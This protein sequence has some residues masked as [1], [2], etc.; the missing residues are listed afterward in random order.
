M[1]AQRTAELAQQ[2][3]ELVSMTMAYKTARAQLAATEDTFQQDREQMIVQHLEDLQNL[4]DSTENSHQAQ[5]T[6]LSD[7]SAALLLQRALECD[8]LQQEVKRLR[9]SLTET[10]AH[11]S[12]RR[13]EQEALA[14]DLCA[15]SAQKQASS[16]SIAQYK[17]AL[18]HMTAERNASQDVVQ[19]HECELKAQA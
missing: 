3:A 18:A 2:T 7:Q 12:K 14:A 1:E 9:A 8:C 4:H 5:L 13:A 19:A 6:Q 16:I 17:Q 10:R 15:L 11:L